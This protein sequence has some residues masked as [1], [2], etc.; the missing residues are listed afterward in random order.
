MENRKVGDNIENMKLMPL[1]SDYTTS[2]E[3]LFQLVQLQQRYLAN[4]D[5]IHIFNIK[6]VDWLLPKKEVSFKTHLLE[7]RH[8]V[9][10]SKLVLF[11]EKLKTL[12]RFSCW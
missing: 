1:R 10:G 7:A 3:T 2:E 8:S 12:T 6:E 9:V 4:I 11:L 5:A